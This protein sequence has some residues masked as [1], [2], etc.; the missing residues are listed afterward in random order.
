MPPSVLPRRAATVG[1]RMTKAS[2]LLVDDDR[3][4]LNS[5]ADWL[6]DQGYSVDTAPNCAAALDVVGGLLGVDL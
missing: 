3:H 2:L 1:D 5:M 6:R 4:V